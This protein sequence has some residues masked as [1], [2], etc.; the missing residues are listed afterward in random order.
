MKKFVILGILGLA[1][2][3]LAVAATVQ[4]P[5]YLDNGNTTDAGAASII[6]TAGTK[7]YIGVK[8]LTGSAI[9]CTVQYFQADGT[10]QTPTA[11]TFTIGANAGLSWRPYADDPQEGAGAAVPNVYNA[12]L[13]KVAGSATITTSAAAAGR[14]VEI[15]QEGSTASYLLPT[16]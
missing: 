16:T 13:A 4:V 2:A 1:A 3:G 11:N 10:D 15:S 14:L 12:T 9:T 6:P 7:A 8:N 5:F